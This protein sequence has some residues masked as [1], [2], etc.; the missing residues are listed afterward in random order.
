MPKAIVLGGGLV[1][2]VIAADLAGD[3]AFK[4]TIADRSADALNAATARCRGRVQSAQADLADAETVRRIVAPFDLVIGAMPGFL[5]YE[6]LRAVL[7]AGKP[8]CDI[9]FMPEDP[10]DLNG[11]AEAHG[12][13][14]VVDCGVAP[15]LSNMIAGYAVGQFDVCD[16]IEIYVGGVPRER[17]WPFEY[18]AGFSP[19]DV[20]EEYTRPARLVEHGRMVTREALSEIERIDFPFIGTLE[21]FNTDGLR[22]LLDTLDVPNMK[23]KTLRY[24]AHASLMSAF[25]EAGFFS[26]E[27]VTL[28]GGQSVRPIDVT[29]ALLF[30]QWQY[31]P[32]EIDLTVMRITAR[33]RSADGATALTWDLFDE[34]DPATGFSSMAR[35]TAFPC[36]IIARRL[37]DG[38]YDEPG[39]IVPETLG[40]R[41]GELA[42][43]LAALETRNVRLRFEKCAAD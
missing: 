19:I 28:A 25:R 17:R 8:Y 31:E 22:S 9:S 42:A 43:M 15:G 26:A 24:P 6:T 5:G 4:V 18:K 35:T 32:G 1:G 12:V 10:R 3:E 34:A 41:D 27:P 29:A 37:I 20:I 39:V 11:L 7:E 38:L 13:T 2:S 16:S 40:Q 23:E 33:G 14:A 21:A 30:P 36:T